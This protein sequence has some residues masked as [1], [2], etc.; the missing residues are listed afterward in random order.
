[1]IK[2]S[3]ST[4][5]IISFLLVA[6]KPSEKEQTPKPQEP[7]FEATMAYAKFKASVRTDLK[8]KNWLTTIN[9]TEPVK[10]IDEIEITKKDSKTE[11]IAKVVL[12]DNREGY[13]KR[14]W[15]GGVPYAVLENVR[16]YDKPNK[17]AQIRA[18]LEPGMIVFFD[19]ETDD[20][21]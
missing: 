19:E 21:K 6:C 20:G 5:I 1:M 10:I 15:L 7:T 9:K 18:T 12:S 4:A 17:A 8:L 11:T 2:S 14:S 13:I 3:F 16:V